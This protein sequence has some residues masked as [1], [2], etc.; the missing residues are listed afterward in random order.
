MFESRTYIDRRKR[1]KGQV[2]SGLIL[3]L[4][5]GESSMNYPDNQYPFR[6]DSNF[7]YFF[8]LDSAGLGGVIDI[9]DGREIVFG[10]DIT[11]EDVIWMGPK[12]A[13]AERAQEVG[14]TETMEL[15]KLEGLVADARA[16]GRAVHYLPPYRGENVLQLQELLGGTPAEIAGGVS[17]ELIRAVVEQRSIKSEEEITEIEAAVAICH[18]M[19]TT[20]MK[21][22][23]PG[24]YEMQVA[25]LMEGVVLSKG[26]RLSFPTIFTVHGETLHNHYHGNIMEDGD[27]IIN[28][29]G[30]ESLLHY[31][32]DITRTIPVGGKFTDLQKDIYNIVLNSQTGA[33]NA[34]RPGVE[35][36]DI[37]VFASEILA[38]GLKDMGLMKGDTKEA[39]QAG[40][41]ALFFQCG[42]GHMMGLDVHDMEGLG[43]D[44]VGYTDSIRR[45]PQFGIKSLRLGR[46]LEPGFVITVEPGLYFIPQLIDLWKSEKKFEQY[47]DYNEV[48]KFRGFGGIRLE[49]DVLV[50]EDGPHLLGPPIPRTI[51]EVEAACLQ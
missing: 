42:L 33:I 8:G 9:D 20:A 36:R 7:L 25:G 50:V 10:D 38:A 17:V 21:A 37:H 22:S 11:I 34:I 29:S 47:I 16:K 41:H 49:D 32:G 15:C 40:A 35:F 12:P 44:Y 45:N 4:G 51:E 18:K 1:L 46:A 43:E 26:S 39:V 3:I 14:V 31:A 5:N 23:Q 28:D 6:Q 13:L 48:E 2:G 30:A 27:I 19:Q 24:L